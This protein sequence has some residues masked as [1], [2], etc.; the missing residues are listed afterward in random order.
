MPNLSTRGWKRRN[1]SQKTGLRAIEIWV[2]DTRRLGFAE[3]CRRQCQLVARADVADD[4]VQQ[5]L[6]DA[7]S[8][9]D[10]WQK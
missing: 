5:I 4:G 10:G 1:P 8:D 2:P 9:V 7:L 6:E 3:E